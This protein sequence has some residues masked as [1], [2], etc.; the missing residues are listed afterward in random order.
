MVLAFAFVLWYNRADLRTG[1]PVS[2]FARAIAFLVSGYKPQFFYWEIVEVFRRVV[3]SG[4]V[5]L[6]PYSE[7]FARI[8]FA[9]VISVNFLCITSMARPWARVEDNMLA[10]VGQSALVLTFACGAVIKMT[11]IPGITDEQ[12][13]TFLGFHSTVGP[14]SV[15]CFIALSFLF[16]LVGIFASMIKWDR[17]KLP[18]TH[19]ATEAQAGQKLSTVGLTIGSCICGLPAGVLGGLAFGL[20]GAIIAAAVLGMLG[21]VVGVV[22]M[23][24][25]QRCLGKLLGRRAVHDE[26]LDEGLQ[27]AFD[28]LDTRLLRLA[29]TSQHNLLKSISPW[30]VRL[31]REIRLRRESASKVTSL[32]MAPMAQHAGELIRQQLASIRR[33]ISRE[34]ASTLLTRVAERIREPTYRLKDFHADM[35]KCFP[36]L[37]LYLGGAEPAADTVEGSARILASKGVLGTQEGTQLMTSGLTGHIEYCRTFGALFSVYWLLRLELPQV[38]DSCDLG[39]Q[40]AFCFGVEPHTWLNMELTASQMRP[41]H[42]KA[43]SNAVH[44]SEDPRWAK[45][46][47]FFNSHDWCQLHQLMLDASLLAPSGDRVTI[48]VARTRAMLVLTAIHDIMKID[49]LLPH[50]LDKHAPFSG[51]G[52]GDI[53]YD[54]DLAL[55]YVLTH[56]IDALPSYA[57]LPAEQRAPVLFTQAELSFNHG[58]LVQAE[59]PPGALLSNFKRLIEDGGL[60]AADVAFYFVHWLTDLAGAEG[61]PLSGAEKFVLKFPHAVL[62]SFIRSFPI[63]QELESLS[64]T[65]LMEHFLTEWWPA[66]LGEAPSGPA[67]I[68]L[69]R[70]V[71]QVQSHAAHL[72]IVSAFGLLPDEDKAVLAC[73]MARTGINN[74]TYTI[75]PVPG[76]P[77]FLVYYSP[78][79]M[80][81]SIEDALT[82][83][84]VLAEVYRA[85][86]ALFPLIEE[87]EAGGSVVVHIDQ[88]KAAGTAKKL[89]TTDLFGGQI[90]LLVRTSPY[91]AVVQSVSLFEDAVLMAPSEEHRVLRF[92]SPMLTA[93]AGGG[94]SSEFESSAGSP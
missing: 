40:Q 16:L 47:D 9:L 7:A 91:E 79:F 10:I 46:L 63:L 18:M 68:A 55:G 82:G 65:A 26:L 39:G 56:D 19:G 70:L 54:H 66:P 53:I 76:G 44:A 80:R 89:C 64:E 94:Q 24:K 81:Q 84:R 86:R 88:L 87:G 51:Y 13:D 83:L 25:L 58:W 11:E 28:D 8:V 49:T 72:T 59:A 2:R 61:S 57:D 36:E 21:A 75:S 69:M 3:V 74:Q 14:F 77:A 12:L 92:G 32:K 35:V 52:A 43:S 50:V 5:V 33:L 67:A 29:R 22:A 20:V 78:A 30:R 60:S 90:Y 23:I 15:L 62:N 85:A 6:I 42:E 41:F 17:I 34:E 1:Q 45:R 73:E 4:W 48:C 27:D 71:V 38:K 31:Q 37:Q 93:G